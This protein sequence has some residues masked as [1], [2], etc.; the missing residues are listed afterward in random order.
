MQSL[1][2]YLA[3]TIALYPLTSA[4]QVLQWYSDSKPLTLMPYRQLLTSGNNPTDGVAIDTSDQH[5]TRCIT[6]HM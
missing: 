6:S 1:K 3:S 2:S 5:N 4:F